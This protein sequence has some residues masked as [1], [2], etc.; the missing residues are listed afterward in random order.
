MV[1]HLL[2]SFWR[3]RPAAGRHVAGRAPALIVT[4]TSV[5]PYYGSDPADEGDLAALD[6][7]VAVAEWIAI[8]GAE[9]SV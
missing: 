4:A 8:D 5:A 1:K 3:P 7:P 2:T 9:V 6:M